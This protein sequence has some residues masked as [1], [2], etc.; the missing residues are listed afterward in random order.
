MLDSSHMLQADSNA[1]RGESTD[2]ADAVFKDTRI[3][4]Y[5]RC[6]VLKFLVRVSLWISIIYPHWQQY[7][8]SGPQSAYPVHHAFCTYSTSL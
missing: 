1:D 8:V 7:A 3:I 2:T 6:A 5:W 4:P